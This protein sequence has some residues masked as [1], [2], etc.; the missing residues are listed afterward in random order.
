LAEAGGVGGDYRTNLKVRDFGDHPAAV[1]KATPV[2]T[3][4]ILKN[5][6]EGY[7]APSFR[8]YI[9]ASG[10]CPP[11]GHHLGSLRTGNYMTRVLLL[12][13]ACILMGASGWAQLRRTRVAP[14]W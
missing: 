4:K 14:H 12:S 2:S 7:S 6:A 8:R 3:C 1:C 11:C 13:C 9:F 5:R 10:K